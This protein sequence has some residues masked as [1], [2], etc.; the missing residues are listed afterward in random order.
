M[1]GEPL[2]VWEKNKD[3]NFDEITNMLYQM[4]LF[5]R[6]SFTEEQLKESA[7]SEKYFDLS[8]KW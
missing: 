4:L 8:S 1:T 3:F 7:E 2:F 6:E 5:T